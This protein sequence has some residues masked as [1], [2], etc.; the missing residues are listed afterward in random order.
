MN[1]H[2]SERAAGRARDDG[3]PARRDCRGRRPRAV[4]HLRDPRE[5]RQ[6]AL[7]AA[8]APQAAEAREPRQDASWS[9]AASRRRIRRAL[10]EQ[11]A[12]GRRHLR[13]AQHGPPA[14]AARRRRLRARC[15]SSRS[16]STPRCS[17]RRCRP[18][19]RSATTPGSPSRSAATTPA[20]SASSR[21]C[22]GREKSRKLGEIVAEV[23]DLV[24]DGV[25]RGHPARP[26]RQLLRPRPRRARPGRRA[27]ATARCSPS[28]CT[29][30]ATSTAWSAC[31]SPARTPR[32]SP[33][34]CSPPC[35]TS[36]TSASSCTCRCSRAPTGS[37]G[38]CSARTAPRATSTSSPRPARRSPALAIST[39][40][41]V[42]FPG[43][44]EDDFADTLRVA[45]ARRLRLGASPSST[46]S[47]PAP[48]RSTSTATWT[49]RSSSERYRRLA[50]LTRRLS[51]RGQRPPGRHR[52]GAAHRGPVQ[53]RP[54]A[55][56]RP[57]PRATAW[58]TSTDHPD[59]PARRPGRTPASNTRPPTTCSARS[60]P[61]PPP[62]ASPVHPRAAPSRLPPPDPP[63]AGAH[64]SPPRA[65]QGVAAAVPSGGY[66]RD[67]APSGPEE[68]ARGSALWWVLARRTPLVLGGEAG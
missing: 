32:T 3:L 52:A 67:A 66:W 24:A 64:A 43:E 14:G 27:R 7:R 28:C 12:V 55:H 16:S 36:P 31:A 63:P 33:P 45:G 59:R 40:I 37:C 35:A 56:E 38:A 29:P 57:H 20:P 23:R 53:D 41:I 26:E 42:G 22:A 5:R 18:G 4:Q 62:R 60:P 13:H 11:G 25:Q 6:Q 44:T 58:S 65:S 8:V 1:E 46:P 34:T 30:W 47:A 51:R 54:R 21:R 2:D 61:T 17:P 49:R 10:A 50:D 68:V 39:D 15:R 19:G 48:P 9:A